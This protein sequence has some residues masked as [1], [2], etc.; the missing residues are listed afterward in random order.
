MG[1]FIE[2]ETYL[3]ALRR[4]FDW[5]WPVVFESEYRFVHVSSRAMRGPI[6]ATPRF[7]RGPA[8]TMG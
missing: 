1:V 6:V 2:F 4:V 3:G 8:S 5:R 7:F